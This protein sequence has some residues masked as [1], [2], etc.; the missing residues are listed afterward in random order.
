MPTF[1]TFKDLSVTFKKHPVSNDLVQ[2]KDK[3]AIVQS[4]TALLL[5]MKGERPFQPQL[6]CNIQ[7]VLF[8]PLDYGSAGLIKSEIRNT[9]NR[10][11]PRININA[12][13][14]VPDFDNNG[15]QVELKYTIIGREDAPVAVEF[16]LE[17]TR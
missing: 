4:I 11:E 5:T 6:G 7:K 10:Y 16:F 8:E 12:I 15:F 13:L 3:A 9:L 1:Q 14:C 17:R 2:V